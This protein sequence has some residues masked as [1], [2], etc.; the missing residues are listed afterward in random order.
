VTP[1]EIEELI[2]DALATAAYD[3]TRGQES[4]S[5][6]IVGRI[7][8]GENRIRVWRQHRG[9]TLD[10]LAAKTGIGKGYLSQIER[11]QRSG[12]LDVYKRLAAALA[13]DIDELAG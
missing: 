5:S 9:L 13:L 7:L 6:E 4:V 1:D 10:Q 2:E 3:R 12:T 8:A 11:G